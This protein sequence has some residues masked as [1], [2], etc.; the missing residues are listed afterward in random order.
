M[1]TFVKEFLHHRKQ[2]KDMLK[3]L[4]RRQ[5]L[6]KMLEMANRLDDGPDRIAAIADIKIQLMLLKLELN[7]YY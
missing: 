3:L 1:F 7:T 6:H 5:R 4:E 2:T